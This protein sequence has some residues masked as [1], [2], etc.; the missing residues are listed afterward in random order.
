MK[1]AIH[2]PNFIPW[3]PYFYKMAMA[4]KFLILNNVQFE[5]NGFQN[6]YKTG[7]DWITKP[8]K[9]GMDLI[10]DKRYTSDRSLNELN[11]NWIN[12]IKETLEIDTEIVYPKW[13]SECSATERLINEIK[14]HSCNTYI[15]N[16]EAKNKYLDEDLMRNSGIEIEYCQ[17]PR[18]LHIHIF[19]AFN[20]YGIEGT[21]KQLPRRKDAIAYAN[22]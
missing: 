9:N 3:M 6:R 12:V 21:I 22:V 20:K 16:P 10:N 2:Q 1:I 4:D 13:G 15:T 17:V 7:E 14:L 19:D 18:H 11:M 8:V 5:K